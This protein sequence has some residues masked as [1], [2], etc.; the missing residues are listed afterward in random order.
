V[1]LASDGHG[2]DDCPVCGV[3]I[4]DTVVDSSSEQGVVTVEQPKKKPS[5]V[6]NL[7]GVC[8]L[9]AVAVIGGLEVRARYSASQAVKKL[10][11]AQAEYEN[12]K[13]TP[14]LTKEQVEKLVGQPPAGPEVQDGAFE[15]Q[16]F[17]WRGLFRKY[18]LNAYYLGDNPKHLDNFGLE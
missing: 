6:R 15:K 4:A 12:N 5:I 18:T 11:E 10:E 17:V 9:I 7:I 2:H 14:P 1:A 16:T 13:S 3:P 8:V